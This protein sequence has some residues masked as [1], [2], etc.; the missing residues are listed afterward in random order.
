MSY[1]A[2]IKQV[3]FINSLIS[4]REWGEEVNFATLTS[5]EASDT[6]SGL[7]RSP[8]KFA[9][10][11]AVGM[12]QTQDLEIYRVHESRETGNLYAKHLT[13]SEGF[14]YVAGAITKLKD[15]DKM[16]FEAAKAYGVLTGQCCVCGIF[17]T[18]EKSVVQGIGPVCAK[19]F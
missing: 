11:L 6:I 14:V 3:S 12:Y 18:D 19:K 7:L 8:R 13:I 17:L 16:S 5:K 10:N 1:P 15:S 4:E 2:S 9:A